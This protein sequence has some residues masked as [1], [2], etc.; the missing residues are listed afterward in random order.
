MKDVL[1]VEIKYYQSSTLLYS[2]AMILNHIV[3]FRGC[4]PKASHNWT[5]AR[6]LAS[7]FD[8]IFFKFPFAN[9]V[10]K[11]AVSYSKVNLFRFCL[12]K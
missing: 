3:S 11:P 2:S 10:A 6:N 7:S 5:V 1:N 12:R 4:F 8:V 9:G